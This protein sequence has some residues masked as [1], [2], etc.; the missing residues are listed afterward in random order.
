MDAI[1]FINWSS[2]LA[3]GV[4]VRPSFDGSLTAAQ[5]IEVIFIGRP[6]PSSTLEDRRLR[7]WVV[8]ST[9]SITNF[10]DDRHKIHT[11]MPV[12]ARDA[13]GWGARRSKVCNQHF[14]ST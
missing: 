11:P 5:R 9:S 1:G 12:I 8:A 3:L 10:N 4:R 14:A 6:S 7:H 2:V 13:M